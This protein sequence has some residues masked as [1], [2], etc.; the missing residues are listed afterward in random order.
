MTTLG[1]Q[2]R[3][4]IPVVPL[5]SEPPRP[6]MHAPPQPHNRFE[7]PQVPQMPQV[8]EF[9]EEQHI[10]K[11]CAPFEREQEE[12]DNI[13][14]DMREGEAEMYDYLLQPDVEKALMEE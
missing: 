4:M 8:P 6:H 13:V 12:L 1:D 11:L 2:L 10:K 7:V 3:A 14:N 9:D 5:I